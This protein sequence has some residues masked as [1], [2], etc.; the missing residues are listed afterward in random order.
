MIFSGF[1]LVALPLLIAVLVAWFNVDR[2]A[3]QGKQALTGGIE[4]TQQSQA[5]VE[6][7]Q[8]MD[9]NARQFLVLRDAELLG[10]YTQRQLELETRL[11]N[12]ETTAVLPDDPNL[13]D[14][15]RATS[16]EIHH[17]LQTLGDDQD[18]QAIL[19]QLNELKV[20][21]RD[22]LNYSE[23]LVN[24]RSRAIQ[25]SAQETRRLLL[26]LLL[27]TIPAAL[28][29]MLI[30]TP[31]ISRSIR[32]VSRA[33]KE[34][35]RG[36][37]KEPVKVGGPPDIRTLGEDLDSLRERL[38]ASEQQQRRFLQH[39]S[40][41]LKTPLASLLEGTELLMDGSVGR[42]E[43]AQMEVAEIL[44]NNTQD[45]RHLIE[46]LLDFSAWQASHTRLQLSRF[47]IFG[48]V[49]QLLDSHRVTLVSKNLHLHLD[50]RHFTIEADKDKLRV[51]LDNLISNAL[52]YA[53]RDGDVNIRVRM[54]ETAVSLEVANS[55]TN[56]PE[57]ERKAIFEPFYT[58][59]PPKDSPMR[60]SGIGLSLVREYVHAHNGTVTLQDGEFEGAHFVIL[61]PQPKEIIDDAT[62]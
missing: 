37:Y 45:M 27:T 15:L 18:T 29:L 41:E 58:G 48:L 43:S 9:R 54:L 1:L 31:V 11:R 21:A 32:R 10:L 4:Q 40:H 5:L 30:L 59:A 42:L 28:I 8:E 34:L 6:R 2:L 12:I 49:R 56:I 53:P 23:Q 39:M 14:E 13:L 60:G 44:G 62:S 46:N 24:M 22:W 38:L 20:G 57:D 47:D 52:K 19:Q 7:V 36:E 55:G 25:E 33:I 17:A 50:V 16:R 61:L 35:T 26:W 51:T 3:K